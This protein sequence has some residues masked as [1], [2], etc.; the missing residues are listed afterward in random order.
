MFFTL[1][2]VEIMSTG[3]RAQA[4]HGEKGHDPEKDGSI[5]NG[6]ETMD[7]DSTHAVSLTR[8]SS[9][10]QSTRTIGSRLTQ[11]L[12][13]RSNA[14]VIDPGPPPDGGLKAWTQALMG[15]LVI[16]NTWG[17]I[18]TF[19]VFQAYYTSELGLEPSAVSWIGSVQMFGH[20]VLGMFS[21]R[22][23]DAGLFYWVTI[24]GMLLVSLSMFLTSL[25]DQYYQLFLAQGV[26]F[27][28]GCGLQ[29]TPATSL[30]YTYFS[31]NKV[32]A[33]A[34]VASG[35]ATGGLVYPTIARQ[36]LPKLGFAW[37]CRISAFM[38]LVV[39]SVYCSLLKPRLPPRQ[40]G[41]MFEWSA[42]REVPYTLYIIG[43]FMVCF[44]QY[45]GFYY[46]G[47]YA[48]QEVDV[49]Y[50]SSVNLLMI[51]NGVGVL[52]RVIPGYLAD[53]YF[54]GYNTL[55]PF[56][57][58][59]ALIMYCW[60]A[61]KSAVGLY[62]FAVF[63]GFSSAGFQGLF[64]PTLASLTKDLSKVGTRTGMGFS[65]VG[66][67]MLTGPPI[68]G[69]LVQK[70]GYL[71]AQMWAGSMIVAGGVMLVLGRLAKT[72]FVLRAKV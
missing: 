39:G 42:F 53:Q 35:S 50:N 52:G 17:M 33:L 51:M 40:S 43:V 27:G 61:V 13:T 16:F 36:L 32:V 60:A 64:P 38:M 62:V 30:V 2:S 54:G 59:S 34:I 1:L 69:A 48:L 14:D 8:I 44:G 63:Y 70:D 37:T 3:R 10:Q 5:D 45:F 15:H 18:S 47:S 68:A 72:G 12:T 65:V 25:C 9:C 20:F 55:I 31:S 41:P 29:F 11:V 23:V 22:A 7:L 19:S 57:F 28:L 56:V 49:S 4:P 71:S 26:L 66:V 21:G 6:Q 24:P 58:V 67:A 46:I